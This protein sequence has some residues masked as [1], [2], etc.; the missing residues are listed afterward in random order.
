MSRSII[1]LAIGVG[2][3]VAQPA[4]AKPGPEFR[5]VAANAATQIEMTGVPLWQSGKFRI[6]TDGTVGHVRR[7][8]H[9]AGAPSVADPVADDPDGFYTVGRWGGMRFDVHGP[10]VGGSLR[11]ECGFD[12]LEGRTV[13]GSITLAEPDMPL[14]LEC[15]FYRGRQAVGGLRIEGVRQTHG[16]AVQTARIGE[17]WID[18]SRV[19]V[20]SLHRTGYLGIKSD[21]PIG[22]AF[23]RDGMDIAAIDLSAA[24]RR[25]IAI[26]RSASEH[27]A[28]VAAAIVLGLFWDP[29]DTDG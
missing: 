24:T 15:R 14:T 20:R 18:G 7:R 19:A 12:R 1:V 29:G 8:S 10:S 4:A 17:T 16:L 3:S 22:Y 26:P 9:G 5:A 6:G 13:S 25:R 2:L 21:M 28:V 27:D 11:G 23:A